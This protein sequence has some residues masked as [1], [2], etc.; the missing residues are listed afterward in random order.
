MAPYSM[1]LRTRVLQDWDEGT[2]A[3]AVAAKYRVSRAWVHRVVQ[4]RRETGEIEPRRQ[5]RWRTPMLDGQTDQLRAL[6][7]AQPDR[8]L[9]E[10]RAALHV[11]QSHDDLA[12]GDAPRGRLPIRVS[13]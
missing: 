2:K 5:T 6:V 12:R 10:I 7:E 13:R 1:G 3:D 9:V 8:T 11:G 4:R